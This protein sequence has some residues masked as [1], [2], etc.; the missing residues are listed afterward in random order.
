MSKPNKPGTSNISQSQQVGALK[1]TEVLNKFQSAVLSQGQ[2]NPK[3]QI[4][5][6][7]KDLQCKA[8]S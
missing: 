3:D 6:L 8:I 1:N 7:F 2:S 4:R 5:S